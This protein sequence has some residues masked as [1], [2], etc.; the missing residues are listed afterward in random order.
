MPCMTFWLGCS[1]LRLC[2]EIIFSH[3]IDFP[4]SSAA[5]FALCELAST[6]DFPCGYFGGIVCQVPHVVLIFFFANMSLS[7]CESQI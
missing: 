1:N 2:R 3:R 5:H 6:A 7:R 4:I